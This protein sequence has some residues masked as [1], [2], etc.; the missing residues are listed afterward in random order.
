MVGTKVSAW[1]HL[2]LQY[3]RKW[4]LHDFSITI[5][6]FK[7]YAVILF[8]WLQ[9]LCGLFWL[10]RRECTSISLDSMHGPTWF[11]SLS[12]HN[13]LSLLRTSL[14]ALFGMLLHIYCIS[15]VGLSLASLIGQ[16]CARSISLHRQEILRLIH[17]QIQLLILWCISS[18][19]RKLS[20]VVHQHA[21]IS[22]SMP[23]PF[24]P[25]MLPIAISQLHLLWGCVI[26]LK[27]G[28][29]HNI[30]SFRSCSNLAVPILQNS[31][32]WAKLSWILLV[33]S[34][35]DDQWAVVTILQF[36]YW[37]CLY[38][39]AAGFCFQHPWL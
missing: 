16:F 18:L 8:F 23:W 7:A 21:L 39:C 17:H 24:D 2:W 29:R 1:G 32:P 38:L 34:T 27:S 11:C 20:A 9:D 22:I 35:Q 13:P 5:E 14:K 37:G 19:G 30:L 36:V 25:P 4:L 10:W 3:I 28:R 33:C 26:D 31:D 15:F 12:L 6:F